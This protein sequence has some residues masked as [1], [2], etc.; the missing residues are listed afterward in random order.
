M[1]ASSTPGVIRCRSRI[2]VASA[3]PAFRRRMMNDPAYADALSEE[4]FGGAHALA[5]LVQ[6][7]CDEVLLDRNLPDL[8][9]REVAEQ[10]RKQYPPKLLRLPSVI[11]PLAPA[12]VSGNNIGQAVTQLNSALAQ[13]GV[14]RV[15][16][17]N[18]LNQITLSQNFLNQDKINLSAQENTLAGVDP[19]KAATNLVQ[20]QIADQAT[21]SATGRILSLP[22]LLDFLK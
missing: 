17:G 21:L 16:Y 18:A 10:I 22:T 1:A 11:S 5:K 20:A 6:F 8:D 13:V 9:A 12:L 3:D 2:L 14:Q 19:A 7:P 15:F 4:A